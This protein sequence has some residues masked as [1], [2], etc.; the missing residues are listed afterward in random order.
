[1]RAR[2]T[3]IALCCLVPFIAIDESGWSA[4]NVFP[5][6]GHESERRASLFI[7]R[8][9]IV[10]FSIQVK[11]EIVSG[12]N[13]VNLFLFQSSISNDCY[14]M[15][16]AWMDNDNG[17]VIGN[18][19]IW[20]WGGEWKGSGIYRSNYFNRMCW[21]LPSI[22]YENT[23]YW[24]MNSIN[25]NS[26]I[27]IRSDLYVGPQLLF[28]RTL[29]TYYSFLSMR[30]MGLGNSP[31][32]ISGSP[33][34]ECEGTQ[35]NRCQGN[36]SPVV[37]IGEFPSANV[38]QPQPRPYDREADNAT[39]FV[40]GLILLVILT[41]MYAIGKRFGLLDDECNTKGRD[42]PDDPDPENP[43]STHPKD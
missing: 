35:R 3:W 41:I 18:N 25:P 21:S 7:E 40:K 26:S 4:A 36:D 27:T 28:C 37:L 43:P 15:L 12:E 1:M 34:S 19:V 30:R 8:V 17:L 29:R 33:E 32:S 22:S 14:L 42:Q 39:T 16:L 31:Q 2:W 24:D 23:T 6:W 5:W 38:I 20:K 10:D 9:S 13:A 11:S